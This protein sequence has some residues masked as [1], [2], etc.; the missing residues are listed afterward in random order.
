MSLK[1]IVWLIPVLV[2]AAAAVVFADPGFIGVA[3]CK[4]CHK[5]QFAS[6]EQTAH[7]GAS[8]RL[9]GADAS[10]AE[11]LA[12]HATGASADLAGVQCEACHGP[13]SDYK[14]LKVMKDR[15]S[16]LAAGLLLPEQSSCEGCHT[17]APHDQAA[18]DYETA[19]SV[20]IH[21][22]KNPG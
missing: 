15:D 2:I 4:M 21:E 13:G 22:F 14:S 17:G 9:E 11:C 8:D 6:W 19:K 16:S 18:F 7:A 12:C 1:R 10:N 20:G 5:V 3:K